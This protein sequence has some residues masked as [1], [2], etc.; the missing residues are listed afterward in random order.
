MSNATTL[1]MPEVAAAIYTVIETPRGPCL[2]HRWGET[3]YPVLEYLHQG[4]G[5]ERLRADFR[6]N[7]EELAVVLRY[8]NE[9]REAIERDYAAIVRY[10]EE[11]RARYEPLTRAL[12]SFTPGMTNAEK[13][14]LLRRR[15]TQLQAE[16][17]SHE[18]NHS[19]G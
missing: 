16:R 11:L 10:S 15:L 19:V 18:N 7:E 17:S 2:A 1:E 9:H 8:I 4:L 12:S 3:L 14:A 6:L 5:H 13:D